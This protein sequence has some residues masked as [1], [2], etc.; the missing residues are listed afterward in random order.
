MMINILT[1]YAFA[2]GFMIVILIS[3]TRTR[4]QLFRPI[5]I[6]A[7]YERK[8]HKKPKRKREHQYKI[9]IQKNIQTKTHKLNCFILQST[10]Y[11]L[12]YS[13]SILSPPLPRHIRMKS[14]ARSLKGDSVYAYE[15]AY[16]P[17]MFSSWSLGEEKR[18]MGI[19]IFTGIIKRSSKWQWSKTRSEEGRGG[20]SE[21]GG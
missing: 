4:F 16:Y 11:S 17:S 9:S 6:S 21:G 7:K 15:L 5:K 19:I 13:S 20:E 14:I 12:L 10:S 8:T 18:E 1:F 3:R 2:E